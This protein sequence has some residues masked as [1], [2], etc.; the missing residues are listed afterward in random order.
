MGNTI[1]ELNLN[2]NVKEKSNFEKYFSIKVNEPISLE[3]YSNKKIDE[4]KSSFE[5]VPYPKDF[6][7]AFDEVLKSQLASPQDQFSSIGEYKELFGKVGEAMLPFKGLIKKEAHTQAVFHGVFSHYSDIKLGESQENRALVLPEFQTGRGK[8]IDML[9]HGIK[10]A[11]Q[12]SSAKEYD[13][14]GLELKGPREGKNADALMEEANKQIHT[15][16]EK[17]VT[18]KTLTDGDK[19]A[20]IGVVFNGQAEDSTSLI[21][22]SEGFQEVEVKH[23]SILSFSQCATR[24]RRGIGIPCTDS[25]DEEKITGKEKERLIKELFSIEAYD[26]KVI[27]KD[28]PQVS[29]D[30]GKVY[31]KVKDNNGNDK[32]LI[33]DN[34]A[35]IKSIENYVL[36]KKNLEIKLKVSSDKEYAIIEAIKEQGS[37]YY[38]RIDDYR[39][40]LDSIFQD[41]KEVIFDKLHQLSNDKQLLENKKYIEDI[42]VLCL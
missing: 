33:I 8:R 2:F 13:P 40:K 10:F 12:A 36:D 24:K 14:V 37:E 30:N 26:K 9:I 4:F 23:S 35:N 42:G 11:D 3:Q 16:Y 19:V 22:S 6:K 1:V 27:I 29:I 17:G 39:I 25:R 18:Y 5:N 34:A 38:L 31:V 20:F 41:G 15:E 21:K 28:S 32:E 7:K